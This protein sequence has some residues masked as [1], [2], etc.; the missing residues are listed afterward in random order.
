[1]TGE[2]ARI[3]YLAALAAESGATAASVETDGRYVAE[4][5]AFLMLR[6][7]KMPDAAAITDLSVDEL[8][9]FLTS[10]AEDDKDEAARAR[11]LATIRGFQRF[12]ARKRGDRRPP[13]R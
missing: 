13:A 12:L 1:M 11:R 10:R 2:D 4:F 5:L 9:V 7:G 3:A 6:D 8:R